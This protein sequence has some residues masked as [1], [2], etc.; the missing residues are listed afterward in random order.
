LFFYGIDHLADIDGDTSCQEPNHQPNI[1]I[2][3]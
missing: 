1:L 3:T 2:R